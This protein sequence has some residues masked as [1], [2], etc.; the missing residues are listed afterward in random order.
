MVLW[1]LSFMVFV[2]SAMVLGNNQKDGY[3]P[4]SAKQKLIEF[5]IAF[6][7]PKDSIKDRVIGW[8]KPYTVSFVALLP[9]SIIFWGAVSNGY[10]CTPS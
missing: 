6:Y 4:G 9:L 2:F 8:Y 3:E 7:F 1:G 10:L 5:V